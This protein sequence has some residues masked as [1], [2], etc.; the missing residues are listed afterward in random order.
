MVST[1]KKHLLFLCL[2]LLVGCPAAPPDPSSSTS[3]PKLSPHLVQTSGSSTTVEKGT[4]KIIPPELSQEFLKK[5][6]A[7]GNVRLTVSGA[8]MEA[9]KTAVFQPQDLESTQRLLVQDIPRGPVTVL[10]EVLNQNNAII[11]QD[12]QDITVEAL[13]INPVTFTVFI[14][15]LDLSTLKGRLS[16]QPKLGAVIDINQ[17]KTTLVVTSPYLATPKEAVLSPGEMLSA[18]PHILEDIPAGAAHLRIDMRRADGS[19][20][21]TDEAVVMIRPNETTAAPFT[22]LNPAEGEGALQLKIGIN[23]AQN[24]YGELEITP[25]KLI[26]EGEPVTLKVINT[27][28]SICHYRFDFG[29]GS[30]IFTSAQPTVTHTYRQ[31]GNFNATVDLEGCFGDTLARETALVKAKERIPKGLLPVLPSEVHVQEQTF[32][33]V[34]LAWKHAPGA[35]GYKL[36]Q[37]GKLVQDNYT[38]SAYTFNGLTSWTVYLFELS[39]FNAFG[40]TE[41]IPVKVET[42]IANALDGRLSNSGGSG[43]GGGSSGAGNPPPPPAAPTVSITAPANGSFVNGS[44]ALTANASS[45]N[46]IVNVEFFDGATSLGVDNTAPYSIN[47]D[48]TLGAS[49]AHTLTAKM[50][51]S[52]GTQVTSTAITVT[53][54]QPPTITGLTASINPLSGLAF[55]V[56]LTCTATDVDD[57]LA[58]TAFSWSTDGGTF[59][60]FGS[61]TGSPVYWTAPTT[62]GGPYTLRCSVADGVNLP[63]SQTV[64]IPVAAN[65]STLNATGG[66]F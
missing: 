27:R 38:F 39:A 53:V 59:G 30:P 55:P 61:P 54:N 34:R 22:L 65:T 23:P 57:T 8:E 58:S 9:V 4:L 20:Y 49:G 41:K 52:A 36:Y 56:L 28:G 44:V 48:T 51:D 26:K 21:Y 32:T 64:T 40:E 16:V 14:D 47:W 3:P 46:A 66:L 29:D 50:T 13:K 63:V 5:F 60:T 33:Y 19:V 45:P 37:N 62:A 6:G 42:N 31:S 10:L 12:S 2:L 11:Y 35:T 18:T 15:G 1:M 43:G 25:S 17:F 24:V 7:I